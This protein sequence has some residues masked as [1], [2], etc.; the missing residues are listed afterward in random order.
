M[1]GFLIFR[2]R[3]MAET[4]RVTSSQSRAL[5]QSR[6]GLYFF[7][8]GLVL[9]ELLASFSYICQRVRT[10]CFASSRSVRVASVSAFKSFA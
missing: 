2:E 5:R 4:T 8:L 7:G 10:S 6:A 3:Q 9:A 1:R